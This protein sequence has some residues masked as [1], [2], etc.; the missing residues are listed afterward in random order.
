M[1][2]VVLMMAMTGS[3][4]TPDFGHRGHCCHSGGHCGHVRHGHGHCGHHRVHHGCH[5]RHHGC[6]VSHGCH[7]G[8]G[9]GH[10]SHGCCGGYVVPG[11]GPGPVGPGP[12]GPGPKKTELSAPATIVVSLPA[13]AKLTIDGN[14]TRSTS[15][16]RVFT[17]PALEM[18]QEYVYSLRAEITRD[19][20]IVAETQTV[21]VRAGAE[22]PVQFTMTSQGIATR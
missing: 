15:A 20:Q 5:H 10:V 2:S 7:G 3:A 4:D 19:G 17:S 21:T 12:N 11:P 8:H 13:E 14:A 6:H 18:G 1:Y 22:I 16:R 9:Y